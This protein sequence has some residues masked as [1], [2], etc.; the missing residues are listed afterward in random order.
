MT[1]IVG[2]V[3]ERQDGSRTKE[4]EEYYR[5][6][7]ERLKA[8]SKENYRANME[9]RKET[10][11]RWYQAN[12]ERVRMKQRENRDPVKENNRKC[13]EAKIV[14]IAKMQAKKRYIKTL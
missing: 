12:K 5:L 10:S 8:K 9:R 13:N 11:R 1:Q 14:K 4:K 3:P 7:R 6:N 2:K